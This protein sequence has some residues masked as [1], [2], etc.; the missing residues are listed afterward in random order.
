MAGVGGNPHDLRE[1]LQ[2][3]TTFKPHWELIFPAVDGG[4]YGEGGGITTSHDTSVS[5]P[6]LP[7]FF[8]NPP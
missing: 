2:T 1:V 6:V 5:V 8:E 7:A 4:T 3:L